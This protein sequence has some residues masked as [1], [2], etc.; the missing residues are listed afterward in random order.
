MFLAC[1]S[2]VLMLSWKELWTPEPPDEME[3]GY[4]VSAVGKVHS[5]VCV[6]VTGMIVV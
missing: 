5:K 2:D 4:F 6:S 3:L 1:C